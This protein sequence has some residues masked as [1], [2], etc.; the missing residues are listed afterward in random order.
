MLEGSD[1]KRSLPMYA[2]DMATTALRA[3]GGEEAAA[4]RSP[5]RAAA[6]FAYAAALKES[7]V[8]EDDLQLL[9]ELAEINALARPPE[10]PA[11]TRILLF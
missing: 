7:G 11:P 2:R 3:I 6:F 1:G 4:E 9:R 8:A 5:E 10:P